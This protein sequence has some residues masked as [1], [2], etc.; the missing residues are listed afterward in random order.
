MAL[1][2]PFGDED[3]CP[4]FAIISL[5][6]DGLEAKSVEPYIGDFCSWQLD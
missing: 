1:A 2:V 6:G 4:G 5:A 3:F